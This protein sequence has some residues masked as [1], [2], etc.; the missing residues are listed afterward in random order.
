MGNAVLI[1]AQPLRDLAVEDYYW[2]PTGPVPCGCDANAGVQRQSVMA[3]KRMSAGGLQ[4][5]IPIE[6][7]QRDEWDCGHPEPISGGRT[8]SEAS[9]EKV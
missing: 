7:L 4:Y 2:E 9:A 8:L 6:C 1:V 3:V 5:P